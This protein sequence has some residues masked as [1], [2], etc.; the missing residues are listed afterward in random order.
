MSLRRVFVLLGKEARLGA[1]NFFLAYSVIFPILLSLVVALVFGDLF[2]G[3]PRLGI[4]SEEPSQV[5]QILQSKESLHVSVYT[6]P[7]ALR[8]DVARGAVEVGM[9]LPAGFDQALRT[10]QSTRI[11]SF[12]WGE[13]SLRDLLIIE[14]A[15]G[16]AIAQ[17][18]ELPSL[19]TVKPVPLGAAEVQSWSQ[20]FLPLLVIMAVLLGGLLAPSTSLIDEKQSRTLVAL[21][22]TPATLLE[23][24]L[25]KVILGLILGLFTGW[26]TLY[27]NDAFAGQALLLILVLALGALAASLLGAL[28]GTLSKDIDTFIAIVKALGILLYAPGILALIPSIPEWVAKVFPT[29]YMVDPVIQISQR[30]AGFGELAGE[31]GIL[32]AFVATLLLALVFVAERQKEKIALAS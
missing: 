9:V 12:R 23:V 25:A 21:T 19:V 3:K 28:L 22:T 14:T 26:A 5:V 4:Y 15:V 20:R 29:Y 18:A 27:L 31:I 6:D 16:N 32:A 30:G 7:Q 11:Q 1:T 8:D 17:V 13:A 24:Y 10:G 2:S